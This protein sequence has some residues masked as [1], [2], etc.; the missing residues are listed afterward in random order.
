MAAESIVN[1]ESVLN[2]DPPA[3]EADDGFAVFGLSQPVLRALEELGYEAPTPIQRA[4][5][6]FML[7]GRDVI[8]QAQTGTGKTA[9][10][11]IPM[12][13][14]IDVK[15]RTPQALV[16]A[17]TR[18]LAVQDADAL[19][20][21]GRYRNVQ[22]LPIYG[23]APYERQ[24][25]ALRDG[26]HV[27]VG[28]PGRV[29]D[30]L[31]RGTLK[32]G[33]VQLV[34]LDEADEMLNMGFLEDVEAILGAL[35]EARGEAAAAGGGDAWREDIR[36]D[37]E[38][39]EQGPDGEGGEDVD[40]TEDHGETHRNGV[41]V[42]PGAPVG[43]DVISVA[44]SLAPVQTA[45]FSATM[46]QQIVRLARRF[47]RDPERIS[48]APEQVTV[49]QIEQVAYEVGG[50]DKLDALAR[51]LDVEA[52]GSAIVFCGTKRTVD[53]VAE[54]LMVRGYHANALHGDMAQ[55]ERERVLRRFRDGQIEV[56]V[57]TD[58]AA[59]GLDISGVTH[60]I[61]FDIPWDPE[62]Y[63][64]RIGRTGRAG[65]A[66][67]AITL[68]T[69]RD[70][71]LL[72]LIE[73]LLKQRIT[74]RHLPTLADVATRRREAAK[75]AVAA[76][77]QEGNLDGYLAIVG[78]LGEQYDPI[79]IGAAALRLWDQARSAA[80][81]ES[82][83]LVG[84]LKAAED[85]ASRAAAAAAAAEEARQA[86]AEFDAD[87]QRPERGMARLLVALGRADGLRPQD[88]VG[89]IANET[90]L[91]GRAV[92]AIDIYDRFAFVDVPQQHAARVVDTLRHT[93]I[94]G[95]PTAARFAQPAANGRAARRE[96]R[97]PRGRA[98]R[99]EPK[100]RP[101]RLTLDGQPAREPRTTRRAGETR[102][103]R[104]LATRLR[105]RPP[106]R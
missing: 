69:P 17:P 74:R 64:H 7:E 53:D 78:E 66:G 30:H 88:L 28:T 31:R 41:S 49:P 106:G 81:G 92:G 43:Q 105:R 45:L 83:T 103:A 102:P 62:S 82:A 75:E 21:I 93:T 84:A 16:L 27:V 48:V 91:P 97:T 33:R 77:V 39:G 42:A 79:E 35:A 94:R 46:P 2:P 38:T 32:L 14:R 44:Q 25:R 90:G 5:I 8:A 24:L 95:Q 73:Q 13:E 22:V 47:M 59:R 34:I 72:R 36:V 18:E 1:Q 57:A 85:E 6:R 68:V 52:P 40:A 19:H 12:M 71:R 87:G 67:D 9:A 3:A 58:V 10:F 80:G 51:V 86:A 101:T 54:R 96:D 100:P 37:V 76:A 60:V 11:G 55:G 56:L 104:P 50:L 63:V 99:P 4:T 89:A 26:V 98:P 29:L 23:G 15:D 70:Y 61:N 20:Q 65:R